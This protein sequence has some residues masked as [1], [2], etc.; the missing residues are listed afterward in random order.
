MLRS[1]DDSVRWALDGTECF[2]GAIA[3]FDR[4]AYDASSLLPGWT[5]RQLVA[6]VA[7]NAGAMNNLVHW[8]K[9]G[10]PTPMYRSPEERTAGIERGLRMSPAALASWVRASA[11][12]LEAAWSQLREAQWSAEVV[13]AQGRSVPAREIPWL[14]AR[15]ICVHL[16]DLGAGLGFADLPED[17][18][19]A[20]RSDV[21]VKRRDVPDVVAPLADELAWLTGRPHKLSNAPTLPPWL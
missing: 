7:A 10:Q 16:V 8:A 3:D 12:T 1:R 14:R 13:T 11:D 4:S 18:L 15:E 5:R 20:L 2:I 6:H 17:F 21:L 9:T 19:R